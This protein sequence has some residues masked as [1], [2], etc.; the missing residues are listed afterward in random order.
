MKSQFSSIFNQIVICN[1][2]EGRALSKGQLAKINKEAK[3]SFSFCKFF[4]L[5]LNKGKK[6]Q[7]TRDQFENATLRLVFRVLILLKI[8]VSFQCLKE[9]LNFNYET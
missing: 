4:D 3:N 7:K 8:Y 9:E 1:P 5:D 2:I 6:L